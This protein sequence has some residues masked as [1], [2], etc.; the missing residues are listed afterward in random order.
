M[1]HYK[2]GNSKRVFDLGET[3]EQTCP[4]CKENAIF[5]VYKNLNLEITAKAPFLNDDSVYFTFCPYC[6]QSF[7]IPYE[8]GTAFEKGDH[9]A[10]R[11]N[12]FDLP[13]RYRL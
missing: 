12:G 4:K 11:S 9:W 13:V 3:Q 10:I 7:L 6:K 5:P 8:M 1:E 2:L